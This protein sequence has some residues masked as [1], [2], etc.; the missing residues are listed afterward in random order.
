MTSQ[1]S[2]IMSALNEKYTEKTVRTVLERSGD[3]LLEIIIVDDCSDE[4]IADTFPTLDKVRII[5]NAERQGLIRSRNIGAEA[6]RGEIVVSMDAH[7]KVSDNWLPPIINRL[8]N[9]YK[10][11]GVPLTKGLDPEKWEETSDPDAKTGWRWN[12]DFFWRKDDGTDESPAFA[13]HCFAF[14]KKWWAESGKLDDGMMMWGGENIEF[15]IRTWLFGGSVEIIRDSV[16]AHYFKTGFIN[17]QMDGNV[18]LANKARIAEVYFD[19]YKLQFY[20]AIG[21]TPGSIKFGDITERKAIRKRLQDPTRDMKWY[22]EKF[23]PELLGVYTTK[24]TRRGEH[25]AVLGAGPSLDNVTPELLK[26]YDCVIGV[27]FNALVFDCDYVV[28]HDVGP[29]NKV[30]NS[31]KYKANQLLVPITLKDGRG[32]PAA[33]SQDL[34][35]DWLVYELGPQDKDNPLKHKQPPFFH[36]AS[37]VHTA[38]HFATFLGAKSVTLFGCDAKIAPDGRSHTRLVKDYNNG[39]YWPNNAETQKYLDRI[40]RGY[41]MLRAAFKK[42][43]IPLLRFDYV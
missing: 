28:F 14:T 39:F 32:K 27:N 1:A 6:A 30:L 24:G 3:E 26:Q 4:P 20:N 36:H 42:W 18:L 38:I 9:N 16:C 43:E 17:Y 40:N 12:L 25:I 22:L 7:V 41:D 10:C 35:K 13:G 37:T 33:I 5:R 29:A 23:Q 2:V 34:C 21:S 11:I 19:D 15:S 31:N 8:S